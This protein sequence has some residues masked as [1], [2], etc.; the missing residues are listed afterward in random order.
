[1]P[2]GLRLLR[3]PESAVA[4]QEAVQGLKEAREGLVSKLGAESRI[5]LRGAILWI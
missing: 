4:I 5:Q 2:R 1:V 3:W